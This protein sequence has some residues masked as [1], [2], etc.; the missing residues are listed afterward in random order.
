MSSPDRYHVYIVW[1]MIGCK[2]LY[3]LALPNSVLS[4]LVFIE[5]LMAKRSGR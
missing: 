5:C 4:E 1:L 2:A 3:E